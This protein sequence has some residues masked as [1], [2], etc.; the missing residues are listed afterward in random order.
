MQVF[1]YCTAL[2]LVFRT[3]VTQ[4]DH[5][6]ISAVVHEAAEFLSTGQRCPGSMG[7]GSAVIPV[8]FTSSMPGLWATGLDRNSPSLC[9]L[10]SWF[11]FGD[12]MMQVL[13]TLQK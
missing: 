6:K 2:L 4:R 10:L 7:S 1:G 3:S 13:S 9:S 11:F 12:S 5:S 8:G